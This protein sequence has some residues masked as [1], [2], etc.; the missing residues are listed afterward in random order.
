MGEVIVQSKKKSRVFVADKPT[1]T[2]FIKSPRIGAQ[3][4]K[5][6]V[7]CPPKRW[8]GQSVSYLQHDEGWRYARGDFE[9]FNPE[10]PLYHQELDFSHPIPDL[11]LKHNNLFGNKRRLT[12]LQ[13][14]GWFAAN[15]QGDELIF[16]DHLQGCYIV[17]LRYLQD[18][19]F[20]YNLVGNYSIE[21]I[22]GW[23]IV[24]TLEMHELQFRHDIMG[25]NQNLWTS[26]MQ[27]N[28]VRY[29]RY[30]NRMTANLTGS[31]TYYCYFIKYF[32]QI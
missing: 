19:F 4:P 3:Q 5:V 21:G 20:Y 12:D 2:I 27:D 10:N 11:T 1:P 28:G 23:S 24:N 6:G 32:D 22:T 26:T 15:Y 18:V 25:T 8:T 17:Q 31:Q 13:G 16:M 9:R 7:A 29:L 30:G 14:N